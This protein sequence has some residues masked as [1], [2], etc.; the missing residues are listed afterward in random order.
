MIK[1]VFYKPRLPFIIR[2][3]REIKP[4]IPLLNVARSSSSKLNLV[5]NSTCRGQAHDKGIALFWG[6][7]PGSLGGSVAKFF[8]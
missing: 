8:F 7:H 3:A 4:V 1:C 6:A 2:A 5:I